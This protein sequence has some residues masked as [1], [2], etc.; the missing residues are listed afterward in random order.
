MADWA[1]DLTVILEQEYA[2]MSRIVD[3]ARLKTNALKSADIAQIDKI[4]SRE[5]P[6]TMQFSSA[7]EKRLR[8]LQKN[9]LER[10]TLRELLEPAGAEYRQKLKDQLNALTELSRELRE[11]NALNG[12][13]TQ[14]RLEFYNYL[15]G[16]QKTTYEN[17]GKAR[18]DEAKLSL[19]DRKA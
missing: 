9:G 19:M 6:L 2:L 11:I 15:L 1:A 3:E 17:N 14:T 10:K 13:L 4:V 12:E 7:E 5:Q 18:H 16:A 8:L